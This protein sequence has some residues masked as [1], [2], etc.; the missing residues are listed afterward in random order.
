MTGLECISLRD[1]PVHL[2]LRPTVLRLLRVQAEEDPLIPSLGKAI[3]IHVGRPYWPRKSW[4]SGGIERPLFCCRTE[5]SGVPERRGRRLQH[6]LEAAR[7]ALVP[8]RICAR[9][10]ALQRSPQRERGKDLDLYSN[11]SPLL[12]WPRGSCLHSSTFL[13]KIYTKIAPTHKH[14]RGAA[15]TPTGCLRNKLAKAAYLHRLLLLLQEMTPCWRLRP[16][17]ERMHVCWES[18]PLNDVTHTLMWRLISRPAE[19]Y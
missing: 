5:S 3:W 11:P 14:Q 13:R 16:L 15:W 4:G 19:Q 12:G 18:C 2:E 6:S 7:A 9:V 17:L 1:P 10:S 8:P